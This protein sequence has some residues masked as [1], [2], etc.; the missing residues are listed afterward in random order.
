MSSI[1]SPCETQD[2][3]DL[4]AGHGIKPARPMHAL[5]ALEAK[6][7]SA[8]ASITAKQTQLQDAE[9]KFQHKISQADAELV[10]ASASLDA[11]STQ[12]NVVESQVEGTPSYCCGR[13]FINIVWL[14]ALT[15]SHRSN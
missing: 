2:V 1:S 12:V 11:I 3:I 14:D 6:L 8:N 9:R 5:A 4:C 10:S 7:T 15:N 13:F